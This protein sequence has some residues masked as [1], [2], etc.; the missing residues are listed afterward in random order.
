MLAAL[1]VA[2]AMLAVGIALGARRSA[3]IRRG[4]VAARGSLHTLVSHSR[5]HPGRFAGGLLASAALT[6]THVLAFACCVLAVGGHGS[7]LSLTIVYL[8]ASTAG[9]FIPTPG[10]AGAVEAALLG[11]LVTT[12][13]PMPIALAAAVLS[14]LESVWLPAIPGWF[15]MRSLRRSGLM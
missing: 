15:A 3:M 5:R 14:R 9:S 8:A 13:V 11:G 10:G 4:L 12:G 2:V 7:L 1:L 6:L